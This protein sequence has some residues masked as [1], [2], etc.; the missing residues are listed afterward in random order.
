MIF[1][2]TDDLSD[3]RVAINSETKTYLFLFRMINK[4]GLMQGPYL[5][6]HQKTTDVSPWWGGFIAAGIYRD[7][8][9]IREDASKYSAVP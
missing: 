9:Q 7:F 6:P 4:K 2:N 5:S 3:S 8:F 1:W